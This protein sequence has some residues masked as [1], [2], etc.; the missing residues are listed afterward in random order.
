[1]KMTTITW[2]AV[3]GVTSYEV[4]IDGANP[5]SVTGTSYD[6]DAA[7]GMRGIY[8]VRSVNPAGKS[9]WSY[10]RYQA[11]DSETEMPLSELSYAIAH[12]GWVP[13][14]AYQSLKAFF[15]PPAPNEISWKLGFKDKS[16]K[17][18]AYEWAHESATREE[19]AE[20]QPGRMKMGNQKLQ[21]INGSLSKDGAAVL[22]YFDGEGHIED[23]D[24]IRVG[25]EQGIGAAKYT[26]VV[27][28]TAGQKVWGLSS[29]APGL[30]PTGYRDSYGAIEVPVKEG[31]KGI[32]LRRLDGVVRYSVVRKDNTREPICAFRCWMNKY[33]ANDPVEIYGWRWGN[34]TIRQMAGKG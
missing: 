4:S 25:W 5:V 32:E 23:K 13:G 29:S 15:L 16:G 8:Q 27:R 31:D 1:M 7:A 9:A 3:P 14:K 17:S 6:F 21:T 30:P 11:A 19:I 10:S 20:G 2:Q 24:T 28:E 22:I 26:V 18:S 33:G 12:G 34:L